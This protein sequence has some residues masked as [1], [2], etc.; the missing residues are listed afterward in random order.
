MARTRTT[1]PARP[2]DPSR[3]AYGNTGSVEPVIL[4]GGI[5]RLAGGAVDSRTTRC[6]GIRNSFVAAGFLA[7]GGVRR[8]PAPRWSPS[9]PRT[10]AGGR[11]GG[12]YP[13]GERRGKKS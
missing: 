13:Q 3:A 2:N 12:P 4:G 11:R 8:P 1:R 9:P 7:G 10:G 5:T 6:S